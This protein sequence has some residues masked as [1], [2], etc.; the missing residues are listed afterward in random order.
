MFKPYYLSL[1][2]LFWALQAHSSATPL[3]TA[4]IWLQLPNAQQLST[5]SQYLRLNAY[6]QQVTLVSQGQWLDIPAKL[7]K[8][9]EIWQGPTRLMMRKITLQEFTCYKA[10]CQ[11]PVMHTD[12]LIT[13]R[14]P[15]EAQHKYQVW[16]GQ[17]H[18]HASAFRRSLKLPLNTTRLTLAQDH[19]T[20]YQLPHNEQVTTYFSEAKKLKVTVRK[21]LTSL[22]D[23]GTVS[24]YINQ[25]PVSIINIGDQQANEYIQHKVSTANTDYIAVPKDSYL[26]VKSHGPTLIKLEQM[27]RGINDTSAAQKYHERMFNPYW[28]NNLNETLSHVYIDAQFN[29]FLNFNFAKANP[30]E[31]RRH[32]DLL[33]T[34]ST[35]RFIWPKANK[36]TTEAHSVVKQVTVKQA[37]RKVLNRLYSSTLK[38]DA[39]V[40]TLNETLT[41]DWAN[42]NRVRNYITLLARTSEDTLLTAITPEQQF[43]VQLTANQHFTKITLPLAFNINTMRFLTDNKTIELAVQVDD[44]LPLPN[45]E[46]LYVQKGTLQEKAPA[47]YAHLNTLNQRTANAYL[48]SITPYIEGSPSISLTSDSQLNHVNEHRLLGNALQYLNSNPV[49]ALPILKQLVSSPN[50]AVKKNAWQLRVKALERLNQQ[51]LAQSY[52]EGLLQSFDPRL[53]IFAATQLITFYQNNNNSYQLQGLCAVFIAELTQCT[54]IS[55]QQFLLQQKYL[56]ALWSVHDSQGVLSLDPTPLQVSNYRSLTDPQPQ[57]K[58]H[59][60]ITHF[61]TDNVLGETSQYKAFSVS[62]GKGVTLKATSNIKLQFRAR[63]LWQESATSGT[64]WLHI[65]TRTKQ[66]IMPL[67]SDIASTAQIPTLSARLSVASESIINLKKG[68]TIYI[69]SDSD[70]F[71]SIRAL[72]KS[73]IDTPQ[74]HTD[75]VDFLFSTPFDEIINTPSIS[76]QTLLTNALWRLEN[77]QLLEHEFIALFARMASEK[78][79]VDLATLMSRVKHFG[80]WQAS[81]EYSDYAGTQ[82]VDSDA[83]LKRSLAEQISRHS[84]KNIQLDGVL[85]RANHTLHLDISELHALPIKLKFTFA[86]TELQPNQ[87]ANVLIEAANQHVVWPVTPHSPV[88]YALTEDQRAHSHIRLNWINPYVSQLLNVSIMVFQQGQWQD[89]DLD[90]KQLFYFATQQQPTVM[91]LQKDQL[92]KIE[93]INEMQRAERVIFHPAGKLFLPSSHSKLSRVFSWQLKPNTHKLSASPPVTPLIAQQPKLIQQ[94]MAQTFIDNTL[95]MDS[96]LTHIEGFMRYG[97]SGIF[98]TSEPLPANHSLDFGIRL[99]NNNKQ[100]WYRIEAAYSLNNHNYDTYAVNAIH[101]WQDNNSHWFTEAALFNRWQDSSVI[102]QSQYAGLARFR[103]GESWRNDKSHRHQWW[104]QPFYYYTSVST[105]EY[106]DDLKINPSIFGFY[107]QDHMHGWQA[108]YEY[109]YQPWVDN[110]VSLGM[111]GIANQDWQSFDNVYFNATVEQYY[112][113]QIFSAQL[114]S[115]YKFADDNRPNDTWQ[116]LTQLSWQTLYDFSDTTA[117]WVKLSWTQDWFNNQHAIGFEVNL[118]NLQNTGFAPFAHDEILFKSLQLSHFAEQDI[119]GH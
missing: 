106:L 37:P 51:R 25:H 43:T 27:H 103:I 104:W 68:Q 87:Y 34:I 44:L 13:F 99:R 20:Y 98:E 107:R 11:L 66:A 78:L 110:Q 92:L 77:E 35:K 5:P 82:L 29:D 114:Q 40:H 94:P 64:Q 88:E 15:S 90:T 47:L 46:L 91:Q 61:G 93:T 108:E 109:R 1:L 8:T 4:P 117:G 54:K 7:L 53:R 23:N 115:I 83:I 65:D 41:F 33:S 31:K 58:D 67:Y 101:N 81:K 118:G 16:L 69:H 84:S 17:Y 62:K 76:L 97:R 57:Q 42:L 3:K 74:P 50:F 32:Q 6:A 71:V 30:I 45:N 48:N 9:V 73:H 102:S 96:N 10:R 55:E 28:V 89:I 38:Q 2:A 14:N 26:T 112:Q 86:P 36:M 116:Y 80:H 75:A 39:L 63:A 18:S 105:Q 19:E 95:A 100:H 24:L 119:Y 56:A 79:P 21:D 49:E 60:Q 72:H 59:Y 52:L 85:L 113:G 22:I 111:G 12:Q 70:S